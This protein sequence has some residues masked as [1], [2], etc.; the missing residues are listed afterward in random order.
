MPV[1][2]MADTVEMFWIEVDWTQS[3]K[4]TR[5][6]CCHP[7]TYSQFIT[8]VSVLGLNTTS[9][10]D[11]SVFYVFCSFLVSFLAFEFVSSTASTYFLTEPFSV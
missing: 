10:S 11:L 1:Q 9:N 4:S 7:A 8:Y 5:L 2:Q 3:R 6:W